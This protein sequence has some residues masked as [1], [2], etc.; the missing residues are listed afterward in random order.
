LLVEKR[1]GKGEIIIGVGII[2]H[3][4]LFA[5]G[6]GVCPS[7]PGIRRGGDDIG[8]DPVFI[9]FYHAI[10]IELAK[11]VKSLA[12]GAWACAV[13]RMQVRG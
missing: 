7:G 8:G 1:I 12:A 9:G 6:I 5:G 2:T 3:I 10:V 4:V 11:L 13:K